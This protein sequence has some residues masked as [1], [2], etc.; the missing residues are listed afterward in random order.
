MLFS[1]SSVRGRLRQSQK[2][3]STLISSLIVNLYIDSKFSSA[4]YQLHKKRIF[5]WNRSR[6]S[7]TRTFWRSLHGV[8]RFRFVRNARVFAGWN[9]TRTWVWFVD[10]NLWQWPIQDYV[11]AFSGKG[12]DYTS[13]YIIACWIWLLE[14]SFDALSGT[15]LV[16]PSRSQFYSK[17]T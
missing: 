14:C 11:Y 13:T 12:H 9:P 16:E 7:K 6:S 5:R 2:P 17:I 15:S 4:R 10:W 8:C 3:P 1:N